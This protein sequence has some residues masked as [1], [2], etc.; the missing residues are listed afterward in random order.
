MKPIIIIDGYN[1]IHQVPEL[2]SLLNT[3]LEAARRRLEQILTDYLLVKKIKIIL[4]YDGS[5]AGI[6]QPYSHTP[7]LQIYF[8]KPPQK[9][10]PEIKK[11]IQQHYKKAQLH[12]ISLD[13]ELIHFA[14]IHKAIILTPI[15]FINRIKG[16]RETFDLAQ[17]YNDTMS[18][19]ELQEWLKIFDADTENHEGKSGS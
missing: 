7:D 17:K 11:I 10:D 4:I 12:L 5:V 1:F 14:R 2:K 15:D 6:G 16:E 19:A 18:D 8:S 3:S 9:A 13:N